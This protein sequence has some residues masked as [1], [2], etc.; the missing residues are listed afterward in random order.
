LDVRNFTE[1]A[2]GLGGRVAPEEVEELLT[3]YH[4]AIAPFVEKHQP[5]VGGFQGDGVFVIFNWP[6]EVSDPER[7]ALTFAVESQRA[8]RPVVAE[9][10]RRWW[11]ELGVGVGSAFGWATIVEVGFPDRRDF[12]PVGPSVN[13]AARLCEKALDGEILMDDRV[14]RHLDNGLEPTEAHFDPWPKGLSK[15]EHFYRVT[16]A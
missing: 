2:G 6:I 13:V 10:Q 3:T 1:F 9:W 15:E 12:T 11:S 7:L 4:G 16:V 5:T 14:V 8:L